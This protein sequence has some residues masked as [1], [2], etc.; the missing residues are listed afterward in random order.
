[1]SDV[2]SPSSPSLSGPRSILRLVQVFARLG[3]HSEGQTLAQLCQSLAL[4]K[5]TLFT[6]LKVLEHA[7]YLTN[8]D[9]VYRLGPQAVALGKIMAESPQRSFPHCAKD[10]LQALSEST[11]ETGFLAILTP[12]DR[13]CTY[14]AAVE[15]DNWLR[16]SVKVG[17]QKPSYATGSGQAMLAYIPD[18]RLQ[19]LLADLEF[20]A[21][22]PK[23]VACTADL[24]L[25]LQ[26]VRKRH[27]S[28]VDSG[29]VAGVTSVAAPIFSAD[30]AVMAA[31]T[32]GGP[33]S[34]V[35]KSLEAVEDAVRASAIDISRI[36]GYRGQWPA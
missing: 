29:T 22:T 28:T 11:G 33:T 32:V 27:V 15:T 2:S 7:D 1:M 26:Q 21:L 8:T 9:G 23:T 31:V 13:Y 34:R 25:R 36:L 10:A 14:V 6:M 19:K 35:N 17:S 4:P 12:D 24:T 20:A 16:F 18:A 5:T 30:G 3:T